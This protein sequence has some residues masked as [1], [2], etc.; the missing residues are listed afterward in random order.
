MDWDFLQ[1][2]KRDGGTVFIRRD[3][4][5]AVEPVSD[6]LTN[7]RFPGSGEG[8]TVYAKCADLID[9]GAGE[10]PTPEPVE[11]EPTPA[12]R[13]PNGGAARKSK[14]SRSRR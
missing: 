9:T 5:T 13:T 10:F 6:K 7:I 14:R 3:A 8:V 4:V 2:R 1:F 12:E 11:V